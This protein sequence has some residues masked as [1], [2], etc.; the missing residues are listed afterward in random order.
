VVAITIGGLTI[1]GALWSQ[2]DEVA[3]MLGILLALLCFGGVTR[4]MR[5]HA[6]IS[7]LDWLLLSVSCVAGSVGMS[8]IIGARRYV[9]TPAQYFGLLFVLASFAV[10]RYVLNRAPTLPR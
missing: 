8:S 4:I 6:P 3:Q 10:T 7:M 2:V 1:S 5:R 9:N